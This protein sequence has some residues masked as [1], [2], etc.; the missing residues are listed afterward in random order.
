MSLITEEKHVEC[1]SENLFCDSFAVRYSDTHTIIAFRSPDRS[2]C[3]NTESENSVTLKETDGFR[4]DLCGERLVFKIHTDPAIEFVVS[5]ADESYDTQRRA[6]YVLKRINYIG[7]LMNEGS[8][9]GTKSDSVEQIVK[10][11]ADYCG[12]NTDI[13]RDSE[14][15][16]FNASTGKINSEG[17]LICSVVAI[18][19]LLFRRL[20]ALRGFNFKYTHSRGLPCLQFSANILLDHDAHG[21]DSEPEYKAVCDLIGSPD[22]FIALSLGAPT[23]EAEEKSDGR[24]CRLN[25]AFCALTRDPLGILRADEWSRK[26]KGIMDGIELDVPGRF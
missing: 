10:L 16:T 24:L 19:S 12:C 4:L 11:I 3:D 8:G 23:I 1:H 26:A 5:P 6:E 14:I 17:A 9:I 18:L 2:I 13:Y 20:S 22:R 7:T 15:L 25:L 21:I